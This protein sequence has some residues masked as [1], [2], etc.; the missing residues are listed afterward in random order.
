MEYP[1][2]A[3]VAVPNP[4]TTKEASTS[5]LMV[6]AE[7]HSSP[8]PPKEEVIYDVVK[9]VRKI[10]ALVSMFD[11]LCLSPVSQSLL[12]HTL[13]DVAAKNGGAQHSSNN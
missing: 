6:T 5:T 10:S 3:F 7:E 13:A 1:I 2:D 11:A 9:H 4:S 12:K 8:L